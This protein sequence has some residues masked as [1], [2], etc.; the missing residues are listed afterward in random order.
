MFSSCKLFSK[1][2]SALFQCFW[3]MMLNKMVTL[4]FSCILHLTF[5]NFIGW[6]LVD[7]KKI[8]I[9]IKTI[10]DSSCCETAACVWW[11]LLFH[12]F[13]KILRQINLYILHCT[14]VVLNKRINFY[15]LQ[16]IRNTHALHKL[17]PEVEVLTPRSFSLCPD[18]KHRNYFI[19]YVAFNT[20]VSREHST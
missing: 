10:M 19:A 18:Q 11:R 1:N 13:G 4:I 5:E 8:W 15:V 6:S 7:E 12:I 3:Y 2:P 9:K 17:F 20:A 14:Y 16:S